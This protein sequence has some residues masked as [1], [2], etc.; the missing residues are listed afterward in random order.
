M[1]EQMLT[2]NVQ[3]FKRVDLIKVDGRIDSSNASELV[4]Q[5]QALADDGRYQL[6]LETGDIDYM[7]SAGLRAMVAALRECKKHSGDLR[8]ANPSTRMTEVLNLA[9]LDNIFGVYDDPL[10]AVGSF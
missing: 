4:D 5:F 2:I 9:G 1:G 8:V 6:V 10:T 3:S 7:S